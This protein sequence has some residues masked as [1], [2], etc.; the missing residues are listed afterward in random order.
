[1]LELLLIPV[2]II[3]SLL[4]VKF[5]KAYLTQV[6][7]IVNF[8]VFIVYVIAAQIE[9]PVAFSMTDNLTF[10]PARLGEIRYLPSI[11]TSMFMHATPL[12][13]IG[14]S[15][16][17][18]L[19]GLPLEERI[20]TRKWGIIYFVTGIAAT[21]SFYIMNINSGTYL[22]GASGAIFGIGGA[23]LVLY[24]KD[25]IP[26]FI[27]PIFIRNAP[28]WL[29][30]GSLFVIE[31]VLTM[32]VVNDNVAHIAHVGGTMAGIILAPMLV[33]AELEESRKTLDINVLKTLA[34]TEEEKTIISKVEN[35]EVED[36]R[37]AWLD[38]FFS[39]VQCPECGT[40]LKRASKIRCKC[41]Q[42]YV[43]M[44]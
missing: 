28:V 23:M 25:R 31:T 6:F 19:I 10:V 36:V 1:M 7:I 22:L 35:E 29:A 34:Q 42:E 16:I 8:I 26:M 37:N 5:K 12:H 43:L 30:V 17:L 40:K 3:L 41:G 15:L 32:M 20:G 13:L 27:G 24:P 18:Y 9:S 14:N 44:K 4:Y 38:Q 33:K 2:L 11:I 21:L 39:T